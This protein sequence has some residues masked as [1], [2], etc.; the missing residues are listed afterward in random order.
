ML[1]CAKASVNPPWPCLK[2]KWE[3]TP[4]CPL[5]DFVAIEVKDEQCGHSPSLAE[6]AH[7]SPGS[8]D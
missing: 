6:Q 7:L 4:P 8:A 3:G 2:Q 1:D 5:V